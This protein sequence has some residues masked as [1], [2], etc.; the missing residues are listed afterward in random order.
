MITARSFPGGGDELQDRLAMRRAADRNMSPT[1]ENASQQEAVMAP[2]ERHPTQ[3]ALTVK[4]VATLL[5]MTTKAIYH[6]AER[7]QLPGKFYVGQ[8]LRFRRT[9]LLRFISEGRGLSP[10]RSR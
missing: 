8:S 7:D 2:I 10:T 5:G 9:D 6:R 3:V 1:L 4:Q